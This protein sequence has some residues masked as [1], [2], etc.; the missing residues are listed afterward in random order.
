MEKKYIIF[1]H[2]FKRELENPTPKDLDVIEELMGIKIYRLS[3][4]RR[5]SE[6][7][8]VERPSSAQ[9]RN[10]VKVFQKFPCSYYRTDITD[11]HDYFG[12]KDE[13]LTYKH[14]STPITNPNWRVGTGVS[15][16]DAVAHLISLAINWSSRGAISWGLW[17][18]K[19]D[20]N[21]F[22]LEFAVDPSP[23]VLFYEEKMSIVETTKER[24]Q[25]ERVKMRLMGAL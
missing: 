16:D 3:R 23:K 21:V 12:W 17:K 8:F 1:N 13:T 5:V 19:G 9:L 7:A 11:K 24:L 22:V 10:V 15:Y 2:V 4:S 20:V 6:F 25:V 14:R 18:G